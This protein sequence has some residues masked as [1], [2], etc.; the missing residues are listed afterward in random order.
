MIGS[1]AVGH[2]GGAC[3]MAMYFS[4]EQAARE[5]ERKE[6]PPKLKEQMEEMDKLTVGQTESLDL[7]EPWLYSP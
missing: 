4:S 1:V 3:T 2:D 7:R 5:A 6:P